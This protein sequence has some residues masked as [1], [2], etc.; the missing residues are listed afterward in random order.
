M[1]KTQYER[2]PQTRCLIK[3]HDR[4]RS[5]HL[6]EVTI[7]PS[8]NRD[9][10]RVMS[11][12]GLRRDPPAHDWNR[13]E[14]GKTE[15]H[16]SSFSLILASTPSSSSPFLFLL[17]AARSTLTSVLGRSWSEWSDLAVWPTLILSLLLLF[18]FSCSNQNLPSHHL[19]PSV[20]FG[21]VYRIIQMYIELSNL[22]II[23]FPNSIQMSIQ[24]YLVFIIQKIPI[25]LT[26]KVSY[27]RTRNHDSNS[28]LLIFIFLVYLEITLLCWQMNHNGH[29][30]FVS[31]E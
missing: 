16:L 29:I 19:H 4:W 22:Y 9:T 6:Y 20:L 21:S 8:K 13:G 24:N 1:R 14:R 26:G 28:F 25:S 31:T 15:A 18:L 10:T 27:F 11:H 17:E 23:I 7:S 12:H 2:R 5:R 30:Y 3:I